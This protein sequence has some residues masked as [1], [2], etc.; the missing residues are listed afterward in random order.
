M[1]FPLNCIQLKFFQYF[2]SK[3]SVQSKTLSQCSYPGNIWPK[4]K[5]ETTTNIY[6][7]A[8]FPAADHLFL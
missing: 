2:L 1:Q 5:N 7:I 4:S 8:N 6:V 3:L